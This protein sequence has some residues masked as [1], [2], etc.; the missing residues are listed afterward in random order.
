MDCLTKQSF[1]NRTIM[2]AIAAQVCSLVH[3]SLFA[4]AL[5]R[6]NKLDCVP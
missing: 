5:A 4:F 2:D 3:K 6:L 1:C